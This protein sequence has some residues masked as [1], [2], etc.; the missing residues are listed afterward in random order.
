MEVTPLLVAIE[1]K[2]CA[3][4]D[5]KV[6]VGECDTLAPPGHGPLSRRQ[7]EQ[8]VAGSWPT[9]YIRADSMFATCALMR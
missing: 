7:C 2:I 1:V 4:G 6:R 3:G 5:G 8:A 9:T